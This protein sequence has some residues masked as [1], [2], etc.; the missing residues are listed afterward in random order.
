ML[1]ILAKSDL[2]RHDIAPDIV[3]EYQMAAR[4][5]FKTWWQRAMTSNGISMAHPTARQGYAIAGELDKREITGTVAPAK[6]ERPDE[7]PIAEQMRAA[8]ERHLA[9]SAALGQTQQ[10]RKMA[11]GLARR[12]ARPGFLS[13]LRA[14]VDEAHAAHLTEQR[15]QRVMEINA[16]HLR[17]ATERRE[18]H[19]AQQQTLQ[20]L[21]RERLAEGDPQPAEAP[22]ADMTTRQQIINTQI[23]ITLSSHLARPFGAQAVG[24]LHLAAI[25]QGLAPGHPLAKD[26]DPT[27]LTDNG[28]LLADARVLAFGLTVPQARQETQQ[29]QTMAETAPHAAQEQAKRVQALL[30]EG[31]SSEAGKLFNRNLPPIKD[32]IGTAIDAIADRPLPPTAQVIVLRA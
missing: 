32:A 20:N 30:R 27:F 18:L 6:A 1:K 7:N 3:N 9:E 25:S 10:E 19:A 24:R 28:K 8:M 22:R 13:R 17:D 4:Y 2:A 15:K 29:L 21:R 26:I 23:L 5:S 16:S 31:F 11:E 14:V 12:R